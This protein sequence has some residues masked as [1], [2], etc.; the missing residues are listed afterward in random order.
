MADGSLLQGSMVLCLESLTLEPKVGILR[1]YLMSI[2]LGILLFIFFHLAGL[3]TRVRRQ[4][5]GLDSPG[6]GTQVGELFQ[7]LRLSV[8]LSG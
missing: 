2:G 3:I 7:E 5:Q 8:E 4:R 6:E 1:L